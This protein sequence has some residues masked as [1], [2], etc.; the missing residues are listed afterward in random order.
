MKTA[1]A[2]VI[3]R[4]RT[5]TPGRQPV[6]DDTCFTRPYECG[7]GPHAHSRTARKEDFLKSQRPVVIVSQLRTRT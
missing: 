6:H 7:S 3:V 5:L 1:R 2:R 4:F